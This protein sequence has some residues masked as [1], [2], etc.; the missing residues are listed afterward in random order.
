M[1]CLVCLIHVRGTGDGWIGGWVDGCREREREGGMRR[2]AQAER[3]REGERETNSGE[4]EEEQETR[5]RNVEGTE[6]S[7]MS[8]SKKAQHR[9]QAPAIKENHMAISACSFRSSSSS[10]SSSCLAGALPRTGD[11]TKD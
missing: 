4:G 10:S 5:R 2:E 6:S 8:N 3:A 7:D 11:T 1:L 9:Y